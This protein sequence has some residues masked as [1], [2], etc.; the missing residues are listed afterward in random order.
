MRIF[1]VTRPDGVSLLRMVEAPEGDITNLVAAE[2][3]KS[4]HLM[5]LPFTEIDEAN[6][7]QDKTFRDA[8]VAEGNKIG[9][10]MEKAR[11]VHLTR[12]RVR[13]DE[14]LAALD[15]ETMMGK[16]VQSEKQVL[17]DLPKTFDLSVFK[18]P[19]DLKSAWP[20]ELK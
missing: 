7:P 14:K 16:D 1:L 20:E 3:E 2:L 12:L 10:D 9:V 4:P 19:D 6:I 11:E 13:R 17:R 5:G 8:W 15:I 18:T